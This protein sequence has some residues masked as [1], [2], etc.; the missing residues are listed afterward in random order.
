ITAE[1]R[2]LLLEAL[3]PPMESPTSPGTPRPWG[4]MVASVALAIALASTGLWWRDFSMLRA[5]AKDV[6]QL[7]VEVAQR[8]SAAVSPPVAEAAPTGAPAPVDTAGPRDSAGAADS[9]PPADS[10]GP[11][12]GAVTTASATL[13]AGPV[14]VAA[15]QPDGK[16]LVL[17]VPYGADALGGSRL[18]VIRQLLDRLTRQAGGGLVDIKTYPGRFCLMGNATDG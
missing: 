15:L 11:G 18:E 6:E 13:P 4:W 1:V 5:M 8:A 10:A 7:R 16:P 3:P 9:V 12:P 17:T 2:A 14:R